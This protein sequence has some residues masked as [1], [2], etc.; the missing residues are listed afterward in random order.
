MC[1]ALSCR[2]RLHLTTFRMKRFGTLG[3]TLRSIGCQ[4]WPGGS[5][6]I[7][8]NTAVETQGKSRTLWPM[9]VLKWQSSKCRVRC[10]SAKRNS[11]A[12]ASLPKSCGNEKTDAVLLIH[13]ICSY[14]QLYYSTSRDTRGEHSKSGHD[15]PFLSVKASSCHQK[16]LAMSPA[17]NIQFRD[18]QLC[19]TNTIPAR[20]CCSKATPA[21]S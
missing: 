20:E 7:D 13:P 6:V 18:K 8:E 11:R 21:N 16:R 15:A 17:S 1:I 9:W 14:T 2:R 10:R 4:I 12:F 5:E 3:S 19:P